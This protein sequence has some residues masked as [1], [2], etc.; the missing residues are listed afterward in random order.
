MKLTRFVGNPILT[1]TGNEW[2][3]RAVFNPAAFEWKGNIYLMYRAQGSDYISRFG[4]VKM[5]GT[6]EVA[7]RNSAAI[8]EPDKESE[9]EKNGVEDPRI[10]HVGNEYYL[11]YIAASKYPTLLDNPPHPR[12]PDWRVRVSVAK[13][14]DFESWFRYGVVISHIDSKD[15][16]MF[17]EKI[18]DQ[19]CL[20]H[21]VVPQ[22]RIVVSENGRNYKERG[23][24]FG[25]RHG[26]WDEQKVGVGA[27]PIKCP[28]GWLLFYHGVDNSDVYRLGIVLLDIHDPSLVIGRTNEPILEPVEEYEKVGRVPNVVFT[29]GAIETQDRYWVYYGGADKVIGVASISKEEVLNWAKEESARSRFHEYEQIGKTVTE[30]TE[31]R[32]KH[33]GQ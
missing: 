15:A 20:L 18:N 16:A 27:P 24:V 25:P 5:N 14:T 30:E 22:V 2:E 10:S 6:T 13:T 33:Q 21:R 19:L 9:Y 7:E 12:K 26:M 23:A 29:C 28:Y 8:F 31:E 3:D 32:R 1:P 17:P 11:V 4:L